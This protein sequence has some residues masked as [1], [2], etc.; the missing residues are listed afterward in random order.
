MLQTE[1]PF[2]HPSAGK[3]WPASFYR[4]ILDAIPDSAAVL[5]AKSNILLVNHAWRRHSECNGG[6]PGAY[7]GRNYL[8]VLD[9]DRKDPS[10]A[11]VRRLLVE[12]LEGSRDGFDFE[13]PCEGPSGIR[14]YLMRVRRVTVEK[15]DVVLMMHVDITQRREAEELAR[16]AAGRDLLTGLFNRRSFLEQG[17]MLAE[18]AAREKR[19]LVVLFMDL[20]GFKPINDRLGHQIGDRVLQMVADRFRG[21]V[22]SSDVLAR[23]GGDEFVVIGLV[24]DARDGRELAERCLAA[25][26]EPLDV[27]SEQVQLSCSIGLVEHVGDG[28]SI[29]ELVNRADHAMYRA[30]TAK[31]NHIHH[32]TDEDER[33]PEDGA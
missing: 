1:S 4:A 25:L 28:T 8:E 30:K 32:A 21:A 15:R 2:L 16:E 31:G 24:R 13:Y 17:S 14:W 27:G 22:R 5:D 6:D 18:I 10:V 19:D 11:Y 3:E 26:S 9:A 20:D 7:I 33:M 29:E 12:L 23:Y